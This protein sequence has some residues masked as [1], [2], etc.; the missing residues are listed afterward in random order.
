MA[1]R[2]TGSRNRTAAVPAPPDAHF[3]ALLRASTA[4]QPP[5]PLPSTVNLGPDPLV[6]GVFQ[7][8]AVVEKSTVYALSGVSMRV[9]EGFDALPEP[10]PFHYSFSFGGS[11]GLGPLVYVFVVSERSSI[12][13][14][15]VGKVLRGTSD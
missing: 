14:T 7:P 10:Y 5:F 6:V 3:S 12:T 2:E 13:T 4:L 1:E 9:G 15:R 8:P 11:K